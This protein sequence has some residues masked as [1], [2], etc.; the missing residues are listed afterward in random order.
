MNIH[1]QVEHSLPKPFPLRNDNGLSPVVN[2]YDRALDRTLTELD[3]QSYGGHTPATRLRANDRSS[4]YP[5]FLRRA[6]VQ[7][8]LCRLQNVHDLIR[9]E[10]QY[11]A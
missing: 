3:A 11:A 10:L 4:V 7:E 8:G 9:Q 6:G 2:T 1:L 5:R